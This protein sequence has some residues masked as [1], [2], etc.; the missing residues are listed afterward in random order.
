MGGAYTA[1]NVTRA[2]RWASSTGMVD[3][4]TLG[5]GSSVAWGV[6]GNGSVVVGQSNTAS[7]GWHAF[8]WTSKGGMT[9]LGSIGGDGAVA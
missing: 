1:D 5:G 7:N 4:G 9:D 2:F 3:L 6:N 8:R